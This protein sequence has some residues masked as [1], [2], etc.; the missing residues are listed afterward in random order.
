MK[1]DK[2]CIVGGGSAGW[3]TA[4]MLI[5]HFG[6]TKKIV[7]VESP[8]PRIGVGESTTQF[9]NDFVRYLGLK[10]EEW[11]PACD[12]TYK[13]S[14][15]FVNFNPNGSFHYPFG[16]SEDVAP[17]TEYMNWRRGKKVD[18]MTFGT[19]YSNVIPVVE[20]AR[21]YPKYLERFTGYHLD[22]LLFADYLKHNYAIPKGVEYIEG[23][24]TNY[25]RTVDGISGVYL[26]SDD[27]YVDADLFIDCTGF[28][29]LLMNEL[30]VPWEDFPTLKTD[31]TWACRLEYEYKEHQLVPYTNCTGLSAGWVWNVPTWSRI[32][33]GYNFCSQY[34]SDED[35]LEEF[36][37][38][39]SVDK[40]HNQFRLL[41]WPT[42]IRKKVW[43]HNVVS[44]GLSAGF[45][46]PLESGGLYSVHEFLWKLIQ[47]LPT[48]QNYWNGYMREQFNFACRDKFHSFRDFVVRH[49]TMG[50]RCDTPFWKH[51]TS[52][53]WNDEI[54]DN[55]VQDWD[56]INKINYLPIGQLY[57]LGGY[58]YDMMPE[59]Y[60]TKSEMNGFSVGD[61]NEAIEERL[62]PDPHRTHGYPR[63]IDYYRSN[64]Y[65]TQ[66]N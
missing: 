48:D 37:Q 30:H 43:S 13:Q 50:S 25:A 17:V 33:T 2:I 35:A 21:L 47:V 4:S 32:G 6:D 18:P 20:D 40:P 58:Q 59:W 66:E 42:G 55:L 51:Y 15:R 1:L 61:Y 31:S 56:G 8:V 53:A 34:I 60:Q 44:I 12:A 29:A 23:T 57:L 11:M 36:K 54:P 41:K 26:G 19:V 39:L 62:R 52:S 16:P 22:A 27:R 38:H 45:I 46:E 24:V 7:L 5:K 64:I 63:A 28:R 10:D 9:F 14:V 3:M 65:K 49:Y